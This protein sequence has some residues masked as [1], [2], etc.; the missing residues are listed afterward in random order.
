[1]GKTSAGLGRPGYTGS[2]LL[3]RYADLEAVGAKDDLELEKIMLDLARDKQPD[4]IIM[5]HGLVDD[6]SHAKG[7]YSAEAGQAVAAAAG[8]LQ[9]SIKQ[10][11]DLGYGII[12][13]AD[14]GQHEY[15]REDGSTGGS[16]GTE[17]DEDCLV[18]L[19]WTK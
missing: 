10:L 8:F 15:K 13:L 14:H 16:H 9:R 5:Q 11:K 6:V 4:F 17:I 1:M 18:P 3:G 2:D 7:P 12:I 19:A